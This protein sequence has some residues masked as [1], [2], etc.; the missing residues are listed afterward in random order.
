MHFL[1]AANKWCDFNMCYA[2]AT[3]PLECGLLQP[4]CASECV[5]CNCNG[6]RLT[7]K[8]SSQ[9]VAVNSLMD[10]SSFSSPFMPFGVCSAAAADAAALDS[11]AQATLMPPH[12]HVILW[13]FISFIHFTLLCVSSYFPLAS[14]TGSRFPRTFNISF[15]TLD[16]RADEDDKIYSI[17]LWFVSEWFVCADK[18]TNK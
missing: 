10:G 1:Q 14:L 7:S 11:H 8:S 16:A 2:S 4:V 17:Y 6:V 9:A 13:L 15:S 3:A 5:R 18:M 12:R